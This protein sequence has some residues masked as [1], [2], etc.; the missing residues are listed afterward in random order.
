VLYVGKLR[1]SYR[2]APPTFIDEA[3]SKFRAHETELGRQDSILSSM[4]FLARSSS[5][6]SK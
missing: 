2:K 5:Q 3:L 1:M 4:D 6:V